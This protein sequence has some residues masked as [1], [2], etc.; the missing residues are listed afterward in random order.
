LLL[1]APVLLP[2]T[3]SMGIDDIHF[4]MVMIV[5]VTLGLI[6]PPVGICLFVACKIGNITMRALWS[7]LALFFYAEI[8]LIVVLVYFPVLSTGL[9]NLMRG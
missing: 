8:T 5:S 3:R 4:S 2:I 9:P 7:E 1:L 6:S